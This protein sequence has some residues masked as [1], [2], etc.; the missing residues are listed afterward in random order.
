MKQVVVVLL[1]F[2][3]A[4]AAQGQ[5]RF[6][7]EDQS[8][9]NNGIMSPSDWDQV[10]CDDVATCVSG[11]CLLFARPLL[12]ARQ[13]L[14][15]CVFHHCQSTHFF[16]P[17]WPTRWQAL[18]PFIPD[19][20]TNTCQDCADSIRR[21]CRYN[22]Q[23]P[24]D[25]WRNITSQRDCFDRHRMHHKRGTCRFEDLGFEILPHVLRANQPTTPCPHPPVIDFSWG[26]PGKQ[27]RF[28]V[29]GIRFIDLL[30]FLYHTNLTHLTVLCVL[31]AFY[32]SLVVDT[33]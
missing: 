17:G 2:F 3:A 12:P 5:D 14:L 29:T 23:S 33:H 15:S 30:S 13:H 26:F 22:Q 7:Y 9:W 11:I 19:N 16:Q 27:A 1:L 28:L 18:T 21:D 6:F 31:M 10:E 32:R 8:D 25:L 20:I 4:R 24:I